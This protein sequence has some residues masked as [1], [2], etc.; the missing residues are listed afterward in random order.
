[1]PRRIQIAT[2]TNARISNEIR[3]AL[4]TGLDADRVADFLSNIDWSGLQG[5][6]P[7]VRARL[8]LME[9]WATEFAEGDVTRSGYIARLVSLLPKRERAQAPPPEANARAVAGQ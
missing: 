3:A 4:R 1:M 5:A 7:A 2:L 8:G 6:T 9:E